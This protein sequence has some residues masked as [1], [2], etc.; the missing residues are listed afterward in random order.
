MRQFG[1]PDPPPA[2]KQKM[3]A[4]AETAGKSFPKCIE[5]AST[6]EMYLLRLRVGVEVIGMRQGEL[7]HRV[8]SAHGRQIRDQRDLRCILATKTAS[9]APARAQSYRDGVVG[10]SLA[11]GHDSRHGVK[12]SDLTRTNLNEQQHSG[13]L[14]RKH[15]NNATCLDV[16]GK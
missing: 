4:L 14:G 2:T 11:C 8:L 12:V 10:F 5:S 9:Q 15:T 6:K 1:Q 7:R 3:N 13:A 16:Q